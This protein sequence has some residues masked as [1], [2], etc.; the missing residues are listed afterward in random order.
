VC[1]GGLSGDNSGERRGGEGEEAREGMGVGE[2]RGK[3]KFGS[4]GV[5]LNSKE[6]EITFKT[7]EVPSKAN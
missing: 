1:V 2:R 4:I 5:F 7:I 6:R 3:S